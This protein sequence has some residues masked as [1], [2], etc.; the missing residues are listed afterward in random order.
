MWNFE[1]G[2]KGDF[3][4]K[5]VRA[6]LAVFHNERRDQQLKFAVQNDPSD[7][8]AFTYITE[9]VAS[10]RSMGLELD[11]TTTLSSWCDLWVVG[12]VMES[13]LVSVPDE[14]VSLQGRSFSIAPSWQYAT[15]LRFRLPRG[16]FSRVEITGKD[17][18]YFDDSHNQHSNPYSLV[19]FSIGRQF[20]GWN[21]TAWSRNIFNERYDTRG[22]FFGNE[23]PDYPSKLYVQ[24]GDPRAFG[25]TVA[26]SF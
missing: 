3:F 13:E 2:L 24:R 25:L 8:L 15:G 5:R 10:G 26:Y 22:F 20:D 9:S 12:S 1:V 17:A 18:F 21:I 7:P 11:T 6:N 4:R 19:N 16:V 23:P 14:S